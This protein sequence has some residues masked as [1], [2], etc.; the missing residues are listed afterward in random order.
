MERTDV[1]EEM[2]ERP[3]MQQWHNGPRPETAATRQQANRGPRRP[4]AAISEERE[5]NHKWHQRVELRTAITSGKQRI[6]QEDPI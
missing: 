5:V 1:W 6:A 2:L 4:T 3:G